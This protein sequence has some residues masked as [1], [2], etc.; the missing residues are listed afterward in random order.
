MPKKF[1]IYLSLYCVILLFV[2]RNIIL[3][4]ATNLLDWRDY[5]FYIWMMFQNF[6]HIT[7]LDFVNFFETNAF[8][9]HKLTLFFI[10]TMLPQS[11]IFLPFFLLTKNL[12][13][14]FNLT[15]IA[16]FVLNFTSLFL[17]WKQIFKKDLIAFFGSLFFIFSPFFHSELGHFTVMSYWPLFF[18]L[19][20]L[21]KGRFNKEK[22]NYI[23]VG[24]FLSIQFLASIY[25]G[26]FMMFSVLIFYMLIYLFKPINIKSKQI[27]SSIV[28]ISFVFIAISGIFVKGYIDMKHLYN[29]KRDIREYIGYSASLSDYLFTTEINS[30]FHKSSFMNLWNKADKN[31]GTHGSFPGF[32]I[33]IPAIFALFK[34]SRNNKTISFSVDMDREKAF[35]FILIILGLL[36]SLGPRLNFNGNYA[37]IPLPYYLLLKFVPGM[38]SL[39]VLARWNFLFFLGFTYFSLITLTKLMGIRY[40]K[41]I[42]ILIF[43]I[44]FLEF[45]P[46][47]IQ[48]AKL[49]Y[50]TDDH[51][52]LKDLCSKEKKVL[53]E[54]PITHLNAGTN[55]R[56]GLQYMTANVMLPSTFHGCLLVNGYSGY[57]LPENFILASTLDEYIKNQQTEEFIKE[58][59]RRK[60]DIVKFNQSYFIKEL[61]PSINSFVL[62]IATQSGVEKIQGDLFLL[63]R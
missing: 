51:Q 59:K 27:F 21:F 4:I 2:F 38:E 53:L 55:I 3:N 41:Y 30:L 42:F 1:L 16:T 28:I 25:L 34:V 17:F 19:Y 5:A 58:I 46:L 7:S 63:H 23:F 8:Y 48:S 39:R 15:F 9:P 56:G 43:V 62:S 26:I 60:I 44:F 37:Y 13:L 61:K 12:I 22:R 31:Q 32:L 49:S 54:L 57:D 11:L 33:F 6:T 24:L 20:F 52:I 35:F 10:D 18:G 50:L 36:F 45:I 47:D 40:Y 14:A 29:A